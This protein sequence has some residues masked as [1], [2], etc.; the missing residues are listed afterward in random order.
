MVATRPGDP[1]P[2]MSG[3][4]TQ[5]TR[6]ERQ[7]RDYN[8]IVVGRFKPRFLDMI[9]AGM[10]CDRQAGAA[11]WEVDRYCLTRVFLHRIQDAA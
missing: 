9:G 3:K 6:I 10:L 2:A 8:Q 1:R 7:W 11:A 4:S 5:N